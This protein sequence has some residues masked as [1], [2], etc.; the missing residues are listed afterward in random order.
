MPKARAAGLRAAIAVVDRVSMST[1]ATAD[2]VGL[3]RAVDVL[4]PS[5]ET[6][7]IG[8]FADEA[9]ARRAWAALKAD[10]AGLFDGL[11]PRYE[12]A[13]LGARGVWVRLKVGPVASAAQARR[14]C[15][16]AGVTDGWCAKSAA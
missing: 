11:Q 8:S 4:K 10:N 6:V 7:Q 12:R 9:A 13:D 2:E 1:T 14:V 5:S 16:A 3:R 15:A